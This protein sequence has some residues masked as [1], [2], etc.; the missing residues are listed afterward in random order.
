DIIT[1]LSMVIVRE[2]IFFVKDGSIVQFDSIKE[3]LDNFR[4]HLEYVRLKR[5]EKDQSDLEYYLDYL[6]A[7]LRFLIFMS[8]KKRTSIEID[9]FLSQ[10]DSKIISKLSSIQAVKVSKE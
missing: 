10:F 5:L 2:D 3:Y 1:K 7:K 9:K 4:I 8:E 6:N